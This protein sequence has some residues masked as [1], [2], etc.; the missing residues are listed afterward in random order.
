MIYREIGTCGGIQRGASFQV[1]QLRSW[2]YDVVVLTEADLGAGNE[3]SDRLES[4]LC[5]KKPDIVIDHDC[6]NEAKFEA[7]I[8]VAHAAGV[9]IIAFWH[10]VFSWQFIMGNP[11]AQ[12]PIH[13][14]RKTNGVI[15]L[16]KFDETFYRVL[17]C[18]A[19]AIPY[20][21]PD[22]MTGFRR[23]E[24]PHRVV[25]SGRIVDLKCP[26]DAIK[27]I[28]R[29]RER[30]PDAELF[31]LGDGPPDLQ[32]EIGSYLSAHPALKPA[33]HLEGFQTDVR[34]Y[35]ERAGIG[36]LTS[37]FEG[38][39]H[40]LVEMKMAALPVVAYALPPIATIDSDDGVEQVPQRDI[41]GAAAAIVRLFEDHA[42][43]VRRG[44]AARASYERLSRFDQQGAYERLFN[45]LARPDGQSELIAVDWRKAAD[46]LGLFASHCVTGFA[47]IDDRL[48]RNKEKFSRQKEIAQE[49]KEKIETL[50]QRVQTLNERLS[51]QEEI[52]Q[53]RKEKIETLSQRVQTLNERLSRQEEI[54]QERKEK[55]ETLSQRVQTLNERLS[56][57][58]EIAQERKE[59]IETLS[60]RAK[61]AA[62]A[63]KVLSMIEKIVEP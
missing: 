14:L 34:P 12:G 17:G 45:D 27:I 43:C 33:V 26:L 6:Y 38:F 21:D 1:E 36:L 54:A 2:G 15:G 49:R 31:M 52:A 24:H 4:I 25:W 13:L 57:Q 28:E 41:A 55:I 18:R 23:T 62:K 20:C 32:S 63:S 58:K 7:D 11:S 39:C 42:E 30:I 56:R 37:K 19:L 59:K 35:L 8:K 61:D 50:S 16:S 3:R 29:V 40:S 47:A 22:I 60:Q 51:R 44:Q 48:R 9:P 53:E 5:D 46:V 10:S